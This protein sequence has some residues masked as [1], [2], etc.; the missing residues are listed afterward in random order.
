MV[1]TARQRRWGKSVVAVVV[2]TWTLLI[3]ALAL[4]CPVCA[5]N[6]D[7]SRSS[8]LAA[9]AV[10]LV[11]PVVLIGGFALWIRSAAKRAA[12]NDATSQRPA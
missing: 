11:V 3:P 1:S 7:D 2:T 10:M 4:A 5:S 9:T 12:A 6:A 8:Y